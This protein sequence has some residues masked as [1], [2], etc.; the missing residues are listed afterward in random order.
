MPG[1]SSRSL[2]ANPPSN[3]STSS[4]N[5]KPHAELDHDYIT[6]VNAPS[7]QDPMDQ[8]GTLQASSTRAS[9][10]RSSSHIRSAS[11]KLPSSLGIGG[12][13]LSRD[14]DLEHRSTPV[15]SSVDGNVESELKR[16]AARPQVIEDEFDSGRCATCDQKVKWP[17]SCAEYRC[18]TCLMINDLTPKVLDKDLP[19]LPLGATEWRKVD[20]LSNGTGCLEY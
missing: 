5:I 12:K 10:T 9:P 4:A 19:D 8:F 11:G 3:S 13:V 17:K 20:N 2:E 7:S 6:Q 16:H 1:W 14:T 15:V 18:G